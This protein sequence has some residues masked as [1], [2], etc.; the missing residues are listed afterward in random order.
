[1]YTVYMHTNIAN[2]K[3]YIGITTQDTKKR[4]KYGNGYKNQLFYRAIKKYGWENFKHDILFTNLT[5]SQAEAKEIELIAQYKSNSPKYGYNTDNGG[6]TIG[7]HSE[8]TKLKIGQA[9]KGHT[10]W[11]NKHHKESTK[12]KLSILKSGSNN[13]NYGKTQ[14]R[15]TK[16]KLSKKIICITTN[17][18]FLI[19]SEGAKK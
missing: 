18:I 14:S 3:R 1:M 10:P 5:K 4:W 9:N 16:L 17:E 2:G 15:E 8:E 12:K 7:T 11:K 19:M 6:K 13:P